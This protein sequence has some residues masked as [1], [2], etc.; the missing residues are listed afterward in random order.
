MLIFIG[1]LIIAFVCFCLLTTFVLTRDRTQSA[2][3]RARSRSSQTGQIVDIEHAQNVVPNPPSGNRGMQMDGLLAISRRVGRL[4]ENLASVQNY[5]SLMLVTQKI[6]CWDIQH[7]HRDLFIH[8]G[9]LLVEHAGN[10]HFLSVRSLSAA[11]ET[12]GVFY[13]EVTV[14]RMQSDLGV[15]FLSDF[16]GMHEMVGHC[17]SS[18]GYWS[19]GSLHCDCSTAD[20]HLDGFPQFTTGDVIGCGLNAFN[21]HVFFTLNGEKLDMGILAADPVRL[22]AAVTLVDNKDAIR[23]N[24]GPSLVFNLSSVLPF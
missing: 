13:F 12:H 7:C 6:N 11:N 10:G 16:I 23:A 4:N 5:L 14:L 1:L 9:A 22:F 17:E 21:R 15:G 18:F 20:A 2:D 8:D 19:Y 24:F 3:A